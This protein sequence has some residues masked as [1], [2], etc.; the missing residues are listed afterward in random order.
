MW[1][2]EVTGKF[3]VEVDRKE[4]IGAGECARLVPQAFDSDDD[5]YVLVRDTAEDVDVE[6]LRRAER[7][8][9]AHAISVVEDE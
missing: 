7:H 1:G 6:L 5:G 3:R 4:C 8:C 9:P 2:T